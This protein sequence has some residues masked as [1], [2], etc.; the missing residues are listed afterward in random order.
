[1]PRKGAFEFV[2]AKSDGSGMG[3]E[4]TL[5]TFYN[6]SLVIEGDCMYQ[7]WSRKETRPLPPSWLPINCLPSTCFL[8]YQMSHVF[9][10]SC[11]L[12]ALLLHSWFLLGF[13]GVV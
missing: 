10:A 13:L 9:W 12:Q 8:T 2:L 3:I 5:K 6:N 4:T 7:G 1:V 11:H